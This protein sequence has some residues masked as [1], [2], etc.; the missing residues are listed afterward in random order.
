MLQ[1]QENL[2]IIAGGDY[3][4]LPDVITGTDYLTRASLR[5]AVPGSATCVTR[6]A[7]RITDIFLMSESFVHSVDHCSS[8]QYFLRPHR[9][10]ALQFT[11]QDEETTVL[12]KPP[13]APQGAALR[14][15]GGG[16]GLERAR[17]G[18]GGGT[19]ASA[20]RS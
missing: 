2:P 12:C 14:A 10:V 9:P 18:T 8:V 6:T 4:M 20:C 17:R 15:R 11:L 16:S 1:Q 19:S 13:S 7:S 3:N 5:I